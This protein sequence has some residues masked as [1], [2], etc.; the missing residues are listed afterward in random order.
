MSAWIDKHLKAIFILPC[1]LFILFM[2]L[3]P[4]GYNIYMSVCKWSMSALSAPSFVGIENYS[5]LLKSSRFWNA[6]WR[7]L[8]FAFVAVFFETLLGIAIAQMLNREFVGKNLSKTLFLLPVVATPVAVGMVWLLIYEPTIGLGNAILTGLGFAPQLFLGSS[9]TAL[10]SLILMDVW[11]WTPMVMLMVLAGMVAIPKEPYESAVVD[12]ASTF[13][14]FRYIT[15]PLASPAILVA[16]LLRLIDAI[17]TFDIIYATTKGGPGFATET[18]NIYASLATFQYYSFGEGAALTMLFF[19][20]VMTL[21]ILFNAIRKK[22][23]V[24]Y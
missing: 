2:I 15:L 14:R 13:Q 23:V 19:V 3:F 24:D 22:A 7:T 10:N 12:G 6:V 20:V 11:E 1:I 4:L 21:A 17:K 9:T 5:F 18:I 8:Y 16:V